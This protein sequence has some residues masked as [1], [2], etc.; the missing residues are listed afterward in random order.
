MED[1]EL[2]LGS[3]AWR[4]AVAPFG[5]SLRRLWVE[6]PRR[7]VLWGYTGAG[8]KQ[9]GQG[10]VLV[11]WPGRIRGGAYPFDGIRHELPRNDKA[12]PNA[13][14]GFARS[15][16]WTTERAAADRARFRLDV[17][18]S[19]H[20]GYPFAVRVEVLYELRRDGLRC[21][22]H[23]ANTGLQAAPFGAGFHPYI[24]PRQALGESVVQ[25]PASLLVERGADLLPTGRVQRVDGTPFDLRE[26]QRLG[27]R[28]LDHTF[29][30]LARD[31]EGLAVVAVDDVEVWMDR[32]C[33]YLQLFT[34][35][36]L[37]PQARKALAVEPM[38][39][40]PDAFN[41]PGLGLA[42]L[43]PGERLSATWGIRLRAA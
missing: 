10:D 11:P 24:L 29:T 21:T 26:R 28:V 13:I 27:D 35:D 31:A 9:G 4:C 41:H 33:G 16:S 17:L 22:V 2:L 43:R 5:A 25:V 23:A 1:A 37:G 30:G 20:P 15:R 6:E 3:G 7:D 32:G 40:G 14:H 18:P 34:G 38:T 39:C 42:V 36:T 12:G 8:A 19:D